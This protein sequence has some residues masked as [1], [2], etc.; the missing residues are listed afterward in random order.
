MIRRMRIA[1][2]FKMPFDYINPSDESAY[3]FPDWER[4][5]PNWEDEG[6]YVEPWERCHRS[7]DEYLYKLDRYR[8][9]GDGS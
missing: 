6:D 4:S 1:W 3:Y 8:P 5:D 7:I 9:H 2:A